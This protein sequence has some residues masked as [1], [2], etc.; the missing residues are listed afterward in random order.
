MLDGKKAV[1][2]VVT[3]GIGVTCVSVIIAT[4]VLHSKDVEPTE[5][6]IEQNPT[7]MTFGQNVEVSFDEEGM[8][9][10]IHENV[11]KVLFKSI[12]NMYKGLT[13]EQKIKVNSVYF[14]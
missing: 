11:G 4:L 7:N 1:F 9:I 8:Q 10:I 3:L 14:F 12:F 5:A 13:S 6:P 2:L